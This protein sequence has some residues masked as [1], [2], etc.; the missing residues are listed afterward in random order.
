MAKDNELKET[1]STNQHLEKIELQPL[2]TLTEESTAH[3]LNKT[4][5]T[6]EGNLPAALFCKHCGEPIN[7]IKQIRQYQI[8]QILAE[9]AA[10]NSYIACEKNN[11]IHNSYQLLNLQ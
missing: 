8:L 3:L 9:E 5:C 7:I 10:I 1:Q 6:H 11:D 4:K 2:Q